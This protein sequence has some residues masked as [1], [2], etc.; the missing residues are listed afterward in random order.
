MFTRWPILPGLVLV[1]GLL[2]T[3]PAQAASPTETMVTFFDQ[4]NASLSEAT[5]DSEPV[6]WP[7]W[8]IG[9]MGD[10]RATPEPSL[11]V[12]NERD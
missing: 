3:A 10:E 8:I 6:S 9:H 1:L 5:A 11:P 2:S 4:A 12:R 7:R